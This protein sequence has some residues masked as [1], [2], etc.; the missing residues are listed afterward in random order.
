MEDNDNVKVSDLMCYLEDCIVLDYGMLHVHMLKCTNLHILYG[1]H[2]LP[3]TNI[4]MCLLALG[5]G[6]VVVYVLVK[7]C[8]ASM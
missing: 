2:V 6:S 8:D 3:I 7:E 1:I 5:E 4:L